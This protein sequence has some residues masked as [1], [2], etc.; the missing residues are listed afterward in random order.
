VDSSFIFNI[1]QTF[2][3]KMSPRTAKQLA[4]HKAARKQRIIMGSLRLFAARGY[5]NTSM[6][7]IA[8]ELK[9]SKGLIYTYFENKEALLNQVVAFALTEA[10][11]L[12]ISERELES[13]P[14]EEIFKRMITGYFELLEEKKELWRLITSL[15]IHVGSIPSVH[16]T[17]S[18]VYERLIGQLEDILRTTGHADPR[19]E[20][21]KLGALMDGIGIQFLIFGQG[22]PIL[23][24]RDSILRSYLKPTNQ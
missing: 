15:A 22:Y 18:E 16:R 2:N 9:I 14:P 1:D 4:A 6:N 7:Q 3:I 13:R 23:Q 17:I 20:A 21:I 10:S 8:T 11:E 5:F 12:N 19:N 24:I